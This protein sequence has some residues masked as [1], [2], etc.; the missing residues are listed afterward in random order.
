MCE[1]FKFYTHE[2]KESFRRLSV[3]TKR[4][5][6]KDGVTPHMRNKQPCVHVNAVYRC[7]SDFVDVLSGLN[8]IKSV[9]N[10]MG[11]EDY[12]KINY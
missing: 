8:D 4:T 7:W 3:I 5:E 1:L 6:S 12:R 2:T 9:H 10:F 11:F